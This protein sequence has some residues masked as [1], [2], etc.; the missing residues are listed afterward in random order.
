MAFF[1]AAALFSVAFY[2][3]H[4][5]QSPEAVGRSPIYWDFNV[6]APIV[7]TFVFG[8]NFPPENESFAGVPETYHFFFDLLTAIPVSF[9]VGLADAFLLVSATTLFALLGSLAG[10]TEELAGTALPGMIAAL[11]ACTSSSLHFF[12][13]WFSDGGSFLSPFRAA[14]DARHP[15]VFS[16]VKGTPFAY[17]GTM[18][19]LF[20]YLEERQ[21][22]FASGFLLAAALLLATRGTWKTSAC[23]AAGAFFG[24]FVF[25]HLFV[26]VSLGFSPSRRTDARPP[27]SSRVWFSSARPSCSGF[28][29]CPGPSGSSRAAGPRCAS[30]R[31]S[32]PCPGGRRS[33]SRRRSATGPMPG[34]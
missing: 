34:G 14:F 11:L 24:L 25:W 10:F 30:T 32:R 17:N 1:A 23:L 18:F 8:D 13:E 7:Q 4:L 6:H 29:A 3:P 21:L 22:V 9:G 2:R 19:N 15:Y 27:S 5:V 31:A 12:T 26:T 28:G 16:F 33:L 20:Y